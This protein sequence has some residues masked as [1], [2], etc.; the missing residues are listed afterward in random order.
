[1]CFVELL[2]SYSS[3]PPDSGK[4]H[5]V[6]NRGPVKRSMAV[7]RSSRGQRVAGSRKTLLQ[8]KALVHVASIW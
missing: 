3:N 2:L 7:K 6:K 1:M 8:R 5:A 4:V